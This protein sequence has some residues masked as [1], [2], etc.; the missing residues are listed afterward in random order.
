ME[1]VLKQLNEMITRNGK[2][3][4]A[5]FWAFIG[6]GTATWIM[7]YLTL[8]G[9]LTWELFVTYLA[10]VAGISQISKLIAYKYGSAPVDTTTVT[11]TSTVNTQSKEVQ[12]NVGAD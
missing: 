6:C 9:Q 4:N 11:A 8:K 12:P 10:S 7:I 2:A 5:K 1:G 3:S